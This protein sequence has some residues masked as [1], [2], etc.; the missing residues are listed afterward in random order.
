MAI[1]SKAVSGS[2]LGFKEVNR[3]SETLV[4]ISQCLCG[5]EDLQ[6]RA[7]QVRDVLV[8]PV[9]LHLCGRG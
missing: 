6:G 2:L 9:N 5:R 7:L 3:L 8:Q 4:C 1:I